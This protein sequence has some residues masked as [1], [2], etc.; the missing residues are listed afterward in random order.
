MVGWKTGK[1]DLFGTDR[2][3]VYLVLIKFS[4]QFAAAAGYGIFRDELY[5]IDCALHLDWGDVD[6]PPLIAMVAWLSMKMFGLSLYGLRLWPALAGAMVVWVTALLVRDLGGGKFA[7]RLARGSITACPK[8]N[9]PRRRSSPTTLAKR[10]RSMCSGPN[11]A[12]PR[13]S[14]KTSPTGFGGLGIIMDKL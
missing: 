2:V 7:Q 8:P 5:D 10:L 13:R 14:A 11:M 9:R 4:I 6:Q 1:S 12:C 3:V